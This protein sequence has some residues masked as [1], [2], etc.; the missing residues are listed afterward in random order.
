MESA[1]EDNALRAAIDLRDAY[2]ASLILW[3]SLDELEGRMTWK[4]VS[5]RQYLYHVRGNLGSGI[6]LGPRSLETEKIF[7]DFRHRKAEVKKTLAATEPDLHRAAAVYVALGLPVLEGWTAKFVQ[8]LDRE[9]LFDDAL[10]IVGTNAMPAYQMEAQV[11]IGQ[12]MHATRDLDLAWVSKQ[13]STKPRLWNA[14]REHLPDLIID[15]ER[16]FQARTRERREIEILVAPSK[17]SS[18]S[19]EPFQ[20]ANL[21][22]QEWL[23]LGEPLRQ[24][25]AGMERTPTALKVPDPRMFALHKSWLADK[26]ERDPIKRPR[27]AKQADMVWRWIRNNMPRY[28]IDTHFK[29]ILPQALLLHFKKLN[30]NLNSKES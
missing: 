2:D 11:R 14:M 25:V 19:R 3:R 1:F 28:P 29:K 30:A 27:D 7:T 22:E 24:V 17:Q 18:F 21:P 20:P 6:S 26:P 23:L 8:H 9:G 13:I 4:T 15:D 12:R 10:L 16:P 5:N